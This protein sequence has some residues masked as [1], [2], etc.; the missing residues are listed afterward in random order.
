[1]TNVRQDG[2]DAGS[3]EA[4]AVADESPRYP[5]RVVC[6]R[7]GLKPATL[8]AWEKRYH[9]VDPGRTQTDRRLYSESDIRRL[10]MLQ[11][12]I[13]AGWRIGQVAQL[14]D[15]E[16]EK[17][18]EST[19]RSRTQP[20]PLAI[21]SVS[22]RTKVVSPARPSRPE[23]ESYL[24]PIWALDSDTLR[25]RLEE[26]LLTET[27]QQVIETVVSPLVEEVGNQWAN[28]SMRPV[29]EHFATAV[30]R[31]FLSS[32]R[33]DFNSGNGD[34]RLIVTTPQGQLHEIGAMIAA[35][36]AEDAG[37]GVTYL[38]PN[39]PAEEIA[40]AARQRQARAVVLSIVLCVERAQLEESLHILRRLL[41]D[42]IAIVAGGRATADI[43]STLEEVNAHVPRTLA[44]YRALLGEW[45]EPVRST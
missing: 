18:L 11:Q 39:L 30:I 14:P 32:L 23:L 29:H 42:S 13:G 41:P 12:A 4:I 34:H 24:E 5:I 21:A 8:R 10:S 17:L 35:N 9:V 27:R 33:N 45:I 2:G 40:L 25:R 20:V 1:L 31:A 6:R 37:W 28:N 7:T 38:G 15:G 3:S 43:S 22:E 16:V 19:P 36:V 44:Q 26:A